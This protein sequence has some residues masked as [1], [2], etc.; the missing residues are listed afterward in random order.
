[1]NMSRV[2]GNVR[3][4]TKQVIV[5]RRLSRLLANP[6]IAIRE[7]DERA[8]AYYDPANKGWVAEPDLFE[9]RVGSSSRYTQSDQ[10]VCF[11][12]LPL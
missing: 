7:W 4:K 8:L 5:T 12:L 11:E 10:T 9:V 3:G 6:A 2:A 1:M